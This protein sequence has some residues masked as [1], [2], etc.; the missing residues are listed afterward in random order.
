MK[1]IL[2]FIALSLIIY[3]CANGNRPV[4]INETYTP[5]D[6]SLF[7]QCSDLKGV[8][9]FIIGKTTFSQV[10]HSKYYKNA[11]G[12]E[13]H[14]NFYNGHW[15]VANKGG[16][17]EKSSWIEKNAKVIKQFPNPGVG[18]KMGDLEFDNFDLAFLNDTL[19]AIYFKTD[20]YKIYNHYLEK[21][22]NGRG[23]LYSYHIDNEPCKDRSKLVVSEDKKEERTW[24]NTDVKLEYHLSY[25]FEMGPNVSSVRTYYNESWY[26]LS[27]KTHYPVF[28]EKYE[29]YCT[30]YD[31]MQSESNSDILNQL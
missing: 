28:I 15:G 31:T 20:S 8:G 6:D 17:Y 18:F 22:G 25:H 19:V 16:K 29:E 11:L 26:L 9:D 13:M 7:L 24:E 4:I 3:S 10:M 14:N 27:S 2:Q 12:L 5:Q 1:R 30:K 23:T 21:Y